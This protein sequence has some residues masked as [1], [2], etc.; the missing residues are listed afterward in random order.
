MNKYLIYTYIA[1]TALADIFFI[2]NIYKL[3]YSDLFIQRMSLHVFT[4]N[5]FTI[6]YILLHWYINKKLKNHE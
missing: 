2:I 5:F 3:G 4:L 6:V 1:I